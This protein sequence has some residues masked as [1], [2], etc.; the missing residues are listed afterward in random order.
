MIPCYGVRDQVLGV[1]E[2]IGPECGLVYVIDD[3]C[4]QHTGDHVE[5]HCSDARVRVLRHERNQGVG[6]AT[7]T[8]YRAA[9]SASADIIVK[10]DGDGQADAA[11]IPQLV[12][13]IIEH[14]SDY[15]KGNRFF[16]LE[17]LKSMPKLRLLG[18]AAL[19]FCAKVSSGYWNLL[20]PNNGF[21]AIHAQVA[22]AIPFTK[23]A[24][25]YFFE[26]DLL[27][28]LG[29]LRAVV[30]DLPMSA[31]YA[32]EPSG[33]RPLRVAPRFV[34][35]HVV[36]SFKRVAYSYFIRDFNPASLQL[37]TGIPLLGFGVSFGIEKWIEAE[38]SGVPASSGTVMLAALPVILGV[39]L[40]SAF[41][42]FDMRNV[43]REPLHPRMSPVSADAA[44][45]GAR[46]P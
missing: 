15:A 21:T 41:L 6:A 26:S 37:L 36:S 3:A 1:L 20:D 16:R 38:Q 24:P 27:F 30:C 39:Q 34:W 18:N 12:R 19:S 13:P 10:L 32:G 31:R 45:T 4:P 22:Q 14:R 35:G 33:L 8:G 44:A 28:R 17:G 46:S 25:G 11:L 40:L 43:P 5:A 9:L 29:T 2:R 42:A 23:L 7:L